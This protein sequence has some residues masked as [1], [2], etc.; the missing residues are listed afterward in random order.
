MEK[1]PNF[2]TKDDHLQKSHNAKSWKRG[3]FGKF[4]DSICCKLSKKVKE[5]LWKH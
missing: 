5:T 1:T 2:S 3:T 4:E